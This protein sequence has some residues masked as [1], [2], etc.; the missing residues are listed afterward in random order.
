MSLPVSRRERSRAWR[1]FGVRQGLQAHHREV[2]ANAHHHV[3]VVDRR[4]VAVDG[5]EHAELVV[6]AFGELAQGVVVGAPGVA[7]VADAVLAVEHHAAGTFE[8]D[9]LFFE[10]AEVDGVC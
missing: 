9:V 3:A 2:A 7:G 8:E 5:V 10:V 1:S 6:E 4:V